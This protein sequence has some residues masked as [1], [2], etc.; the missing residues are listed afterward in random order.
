[1]ADARKTRAATA[2]EAAARK[3]KGKQQAPNQTGAAA[4]NPITPLVDEQGR[5]VQD[6][7]QL[8]NRAR[9]ARR[10]IDA[11][12]FTQWTQGDEEAVQA[13]NPR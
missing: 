6:A 10:D 13:A 3:G 8:I 12:T 1:M 4:V 11:P 5:Q 2:A 7:R 9:E